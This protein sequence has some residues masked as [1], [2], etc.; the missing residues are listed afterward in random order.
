VAAEVLEEAGGP[1][2]RWND[3]TPANGSHVRYGDAVTLRARVRDVSDIAQVRFRA[4]Y[5]R[6]PQIEDDA[7]LTGFDPSTTWRQ[8]AVCSA[9][10]LDE[11]G[12]GSL[13]GWDGDARDARVTYVWDPLVSRAQPSAP[14]L[15]RARRAMT[16]AASRCVPVSL[17]VEVIDRAGHVHSEVS[18]LP[19]PSACDDAAAE[20]REGA[21]LLYL[22]PLVPPRAPGMV[23][24]P[25]WR[26]FK[27]RPS[28]RDDGIVRWRDRA[29]NEDGYR[30]YARRAYFATDCE[31]EFG[32][33]V[34]IEELAADT[35]RYAPRHA[36]IIRRTPVDLPDAPGVLTGYEL[37]VAA[38]NEAG[39]S[40]RLHAG[41]FQKER[42]IFCDTGL[43]PPPGL[44]P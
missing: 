4:Y 24:P 10:G 40:S 44:E 39:E 32:P 17:A 1:R 7:V 21:R 2:A 43:A 42:A 19:T 30:I 28:D 23:A 29:D 41:T 20:A 31:I 14:W 37:Y 18:R 16:R 27:P 35:R 5:P 34:L 15:P 3:Q 12:F 36:A 38:F 8:L 25:N 26:P 6:W 13:C 33:L 9:P 22:D 11:D